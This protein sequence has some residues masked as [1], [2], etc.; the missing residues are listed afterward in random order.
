MRTFPRVSFQ[1][2]GWVM[3]NSWALA[4]GNLDLGGRAAVG[5]GWEHSMGKCPGG[6]GQTRLGKLVEFT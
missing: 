2:Q 3:Q 4:W 6:R 5:S 1:L